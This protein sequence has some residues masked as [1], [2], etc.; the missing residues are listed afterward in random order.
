M[1]SLYCEEHEEEMANFYDSLS[2]NDRRRYA[3]VEAKKI[4]HGG[5]TYIC[6]L[7]GCDDKTVKKGMLD[8]HVD[9]ALQQASV[10]APGGGRKR[11]LYHFG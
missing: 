11:A 5:T 8:L 7:F 1:S 4:G 2:E 9:E 3:A 6:S 10:R